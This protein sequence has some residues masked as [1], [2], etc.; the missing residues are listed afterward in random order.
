MAI[1]EKDSMDHL[2][3]VL[4]MLR[5]AGNNPQVNFYFSKKDIIK[6]KEKWK[7]IVWSGLF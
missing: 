6:K 4:G 1:A 2:V 3:E 7:M 5:S